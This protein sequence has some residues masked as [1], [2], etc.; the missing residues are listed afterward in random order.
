LRP[1]VSGYKIA[2]RPAQTTEDCRGLSQV[3][4]KRKFRQTFDRGPKS[5]VYCKAS[6]LTN[7][8]LQKAVTN[9]R[10]GQSKSVET[11]K[12]FDQ[13]LKTVS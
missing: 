7:K 5:V 1:C 10:S 3:D 4:E 8:S 13:T 12:Y 9:S 6:L 11:L 2:P